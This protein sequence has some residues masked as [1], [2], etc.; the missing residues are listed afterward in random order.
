LGV[1]FAVSFVIFRIILWP[2]VSYYFWI[3]C[4]EVIR[5]KTAHSVPVVWLYLIANIGLTI[6]QFVWL[7][8]IFKTAIKLFSGSGELV[9]E[10]GSSTKSK[11]EE[12]IHGS[13]TVP[14]K[15][16]NKKSN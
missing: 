4:L 7:G 10:R 5:N 2:Y 8:E 9:V 15:K 1:A 13:T 3:D 6:L 12:G 14:S 11:P 16:G